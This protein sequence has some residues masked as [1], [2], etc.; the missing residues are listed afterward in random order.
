MA[1]IW[2]GTQRIAAVDTAP[3]RGRARVEQMKRCSEGPR[4]GK[5]KRAPTREGH[6]AQART[7]DR[8]VREAQAVLP[9]LMTFG[10]VLKAYASG[11]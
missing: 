9:T 10:V 1:V 6:P 8:Q 7:A 11:M 4:Q 5:G 2:E 3:V